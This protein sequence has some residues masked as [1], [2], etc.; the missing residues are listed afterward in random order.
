V[1]NF[2]KEN[3]SNDNVEKLTAFIQAVDTEGNSHLVNVP[4]GPH[5]LTDMITSSPVLGSTPQPGFGAPSAATVPVAAA[6]G[7]TM[8]NGGGLG[9]ADNTEEALLAYALRISME[10]ARDK[11]QKAESKEPKAEA[12]KMETEA[13]TNVE[14][15]AAPE[16]SEMEVEDEELDEEDELAQA[17]ALSMAMAEE[18]EEEEEE[19]KE[20]A[21]ENAEEGD[22]DD[23]ILKVFKEEKFIE[24]L[25]DSTGVP[26]D[27]VDI[28]KI[29]NFDQ[30][31]G[32][33][34]EDEEKN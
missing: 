8:N 30:E 28:E 3:A 20:D 26:K 11:Q 2:G 32:E 18:E 29:L 6:T 9:P 31:E 25:I 27:D 13:N 14:A 34:K 21:D 17:M 24:D 23:D 12:Q 5:R 15:S 22:V 16:G 33:K 4:P 7:G 19:K 1:I 10:E